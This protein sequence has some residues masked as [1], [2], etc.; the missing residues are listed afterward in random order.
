LKKKAAASRLL[1]EPAAL[2]L[3]HADL[4]CQDNLPGRN[5]QGRSQLFS[6]F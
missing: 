3:S 1:R 4:A 2:A 5:Q 6:I